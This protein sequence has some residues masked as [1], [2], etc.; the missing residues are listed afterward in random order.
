MII[1]TM[2]FIEGISDQP[3]Q[4]VSKEK[5]GTAACVGKTMDKIPFLTASVNR[6]LATAV[7]IDV[8]PITS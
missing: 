2:D 1:R 5:T 8:T 3:I 7:T 6:T 4:R